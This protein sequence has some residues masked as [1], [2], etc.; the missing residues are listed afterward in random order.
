MSDAIRSSP[1]EFALIVCHVNE[2]NLWDLTYSSSNAPSPPTQLYFYPRQVPDWPKR[3]ESIVETFS[4]FDFQCRNVLGSSD[5]FLLKQILKLIRPV[6]PD[7]ISPFWKKKLT[8][9]LE[10]KNI[11]LKK[12]P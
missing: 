7:I 3:A 10:M 8:I 1:F 4:F 11:H 9:Y 2:Q 12:I 6:T 5:Y